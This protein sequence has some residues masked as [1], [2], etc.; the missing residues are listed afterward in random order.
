MTNSGG[1]GRCFG[2]V[3]GAEGSAWEALLEVEPCQRDAGGAE[4]SGAT[5]VKDRGPCKMQLW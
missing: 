1:L 3:G 2:R 4:W 5:W